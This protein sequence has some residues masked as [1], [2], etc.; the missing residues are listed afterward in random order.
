MRTVDYD[1]Q[2]LMP[3]TV[4]VEPAMGRDAYSRMIYGPA[5]SY[6]CR[7]EQSTSLVRDQDGRER[8]SNIQ[9]FF[10]TAV[11][12]RHDSRIVFADGSTGEPMSI[13]ATSDEDG[14]LFTKVSL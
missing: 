14:L 11:P 9:V 4:T 12:I 10:Y 2:L 1:L 5:T 8:V 3:D 6:R 7:V 13:E